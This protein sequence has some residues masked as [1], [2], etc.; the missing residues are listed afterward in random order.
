MS[1]RR[2]AF[3]MFVPCTLLTGGQ[4][5]GQ[6][7]PQKVEQLEREN[8]DLKARVE[9]LEQGAPAP[10]LEDELEALGAPGTSG[11]KAKREDEGAAQLKMGGVKLAESGLSQAFG[12]LYTKPFLTSAGNVA[13][14]GYVDL[15]YRDAEND[16]RSFRFH[17]LVPFIYGQPSEHVRFATEIEIEDGHEVEVEFAVIDLLLA[18]P[19]NFRGGVILSPLGK[20]N[21]VHDS[22]VNE[23]TDRPLV[24]TTILPTSLRE[25]GIGGF[26]TLASADSAVGLVTYEAYLTT[27]FKGLLDDGTAAFNTEDGL[28]EGRPH[29]ELG[30]EHAFE[31]INNAF[32]GVGRVAMSPV[33]GTEVGVSAH[34]GKY[35]ESGDNDLTIFA[36]DAALDGRALAQLIG[37]DGTAARVMGAFEFLGEYGDAHVERDDLARASGVPSRLQGWYGQVNYRLYPEFLQS[38]VDRGYLDDGAHFTFVVRRDETEIEHFERD[39]WTFGFN[40]RPNRY[41][42]VFKFDYQINTEGGLT[43]NEDNDAFLFSIATYF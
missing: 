20:F 8:K 38:L 37:L 15:E 17:R 13:L 27:G 19:F 11:A 29:E 12:G 7:I 43:P 21:L 18:D 31:D 41:Q 26:G 39:R 3:W 28:R 24:D 23:L 4:A 6:E 10:T 1:G 33:L 25:A 14:G 30:S 36:I 2:I 35:D 16:D 42:T 22:P 40:F 34:H 9:R 32:A 5:F